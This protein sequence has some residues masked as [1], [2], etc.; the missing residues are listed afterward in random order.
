MSREMK[1][2]VSI[3]MIA[4]MSVQMLIHS[5]AGGNSNLSI[6]RMEDESGNLYA[7]EQEENIKTRIVKLYDDTNRLVL[8]L[9]FDKTTGTLKNLNTGYSLEI[10]GM[11]KKIGPCS[12]LSDK[13]YE[14]EFCSLGESYTSTST[15]TVGEIV[16]MVGVTASVVTIAAIIASM[17][18][19]AV[20][21]GAAQ[22]KV[23]MLAKEIAALIAAGNSDHVIEM[24]FQ[25]VCREVWEA[26]E[27]YPD[28][29][30]WF[31]GYVVDSSYFDFNI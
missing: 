28:G 5:Y 18:G 19:I 10:P 13:D 26:D 8:T 4:I 3:F 17:A 9:E 21:Q 23:K 29:G 30:F 14:Y 15:I 1:R 6:L 16:D 31:L 12:V 25:F 7:L 2:Y 24:E 11:D 20:F 27:S 22:N